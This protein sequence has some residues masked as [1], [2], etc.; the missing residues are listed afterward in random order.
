MVSSEWI[1]AEWPGIH[2]SR[3]TLSWPEGAAVPA[4]RELTFEL[5]AALRAAPSLPL[6]LPGKIA[7]QESDQ[8]RLRAIVLPFIL[9][10]HSA[11]VHRQ[12]APT[13]RQEFAA[14]HCG[15]PV[16]LEKALDEMRFGRVFGDV[17]LLHV[18]DLVP[19]QLFVIIHLIL[20]TLVSLVPFQ[21]VMSIGKDLCTPQELAARIKRE[22]AMWAGVVK[23]AGI[24]AE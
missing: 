20:L 24:K 5:L 8:Q 11:H 23:E 12:L 10:P 16:G 17:D 19:F 7:I 3:V 21:L 4:L 2:S 18:R 6:V 22:S 1:P 13:A 14:H 15:D 9:D